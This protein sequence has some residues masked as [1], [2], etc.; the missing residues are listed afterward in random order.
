M[1]YL[2]QLLL[3]ICLMFL[4]SCTTTSSEKRVIKMD[5]DDP[6]DV[7]VTMLNYVL[8]L[9]INGV[10]ME[11]V[12]K[13]GKNGVVHTAVGEFNIPKNLDEI[14]TKV[15]Q[16]L[17]EG[18]AKAEVCINSS[19]DFFESG[20]YAKFIYRDKNSGNEVVVILDEDK[21][22][23]N[24]TETEEVSK[25]ESVG[26]F[27]KRYV[28]C[29][30]EPTLE[31]GVYRDVCLGIGQTSYHFENENKILIHWGAWN[32]MFYED[33]SRAWFQQFENTE[34]NSDERSF[35][36]SIVFDKR[37]KM[38]PDEVQWNFEML[39]NEDYSEIIGGQVESVAEDGAVSVPMV[40]QSSDH[41]RADRVDDTWYVWYV[42][43]PN[44]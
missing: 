6:Q 35:R 15:V 34:F 9:E 39:F 8:P 25:I 18:M 28:Q 1:N 36:G 24:K 27:Q 29:F 14:G 21:C 7:Y 41:S 44:G 31:V 38:F 13:E 43:S 22:F 19:K 16:K 12:Y 32:D 30:A 2:R 26:P 10:T 37:L 33:D 5:T 20:L 17:F 11:E 23:G 3:V 40:Y 42:L 4:H